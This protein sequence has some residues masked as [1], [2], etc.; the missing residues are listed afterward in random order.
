MLEVARVVQLVLRRVPL[1]GQMARVVAAGVVRVRVVEAVVVRWAHLAECL[2]PSHVRRKATQVLRH[3][4]RSDGLH[5]VIHVVLPTKPTAMT[6]IKVDGSLRSRF[7]KRLHCVGHTLLVCRLGRG[8]TAPRVGQVR[9]EIRQGVRLDHQHDGNL[10]VVLL[11]HR[12]NGV[13]VVLPVLCDA[14]RAL[15]PSIIVAPAILLVCAADLT[16]RSLRVAVAVR[17]VIDDEGH[18]LRLI[19][20]GGVGQDALHGVGGLPCDLMLVVEPVGRGDTAHILE[21]L[22]HVALC[23]R[24]GGLK[25]PL[26]RGVDIEGMTAEGISTRGEHRDVRLHLQKLRCRL[27]LESR[28]L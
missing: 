24:N 22:L 14:L 9:G 23:R 5:E 19:L 15:A 10:S 6:S 26:V 8:V 27:G 2:I 4:E 18:K 25:G 28:G 3:I 17:Q 1:R 21:G 12:G 11:Q 7:R 16:I 13:D 20:R